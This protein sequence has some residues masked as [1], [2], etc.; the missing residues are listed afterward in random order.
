MKLFKTLMILGLSTLCMANQII[1]DDHEIDLGITLGTPGKISF[2]EVVELQIIRTFDSPKVVTISFEVEAKDQHCLNGQN[3]FID[4]R[5][6]GK[7]CFN[8]SV[9]YLGT[10]T[11]SFKLNFEDAYPLEKLKNEQQVFNLKLI[12][13]PIKKDNYIMEIVENN[14][15]HGDIPIRETGW[16]TFGAPEFKLKNT[17]SQSSIHF[18]G[19]KPCRE[20]DAEK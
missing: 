19:I 12:Y 8:S 6:I 13:A 14:V 15:E 4:G 10:Q 5:Y 2:D 17:C 1:L 11:V 9:D 3:H 16:W 7:K 20:V 18:E